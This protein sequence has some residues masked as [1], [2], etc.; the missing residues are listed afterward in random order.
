MH[1]LGFSSLQKMNYNCYMGLKDHS[2]TLINL[3]SDSTYGCD[4]TCLIETATT[5]II[6]EDLIHLFQTLQF[7]VQSCYVPCFIGHVKFYS[8]VPEPLGKM[9]Q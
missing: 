6:Q 2:S 3:F 8:Q 5:H 7:S 1:D 4:V 9:L